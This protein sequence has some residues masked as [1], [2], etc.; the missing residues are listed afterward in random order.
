MIRISGI[1]LPEKKK[2]FAGLATVYGIGKHNVYDILAKAKI[3]QEKR[4]GDLTSEEVVRL[5]KV[6]D[7]I[8]VEGVLKKQVS[9]DIQR[10]R[11]IGSYRGLR[12]TQG[13]PVRGQ[14]TRSNA[15]TKRGRRVTIGA[16]RKEM[17]AKMEDSKKKKETN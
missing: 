6:I 8:P 17:A 11:T 1:N 16:M 3:D 12:H 2:V 7:E 5:Q 14:R 13:L 4:I 9:Q 10:H 15:R